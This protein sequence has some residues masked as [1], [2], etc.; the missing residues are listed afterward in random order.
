[1]TTFKPCYVWPNKAF[2]FRLYLNDHNIRIFILENLQHNFEWLLEYSKDFRSTDHFY[3]IIGCHYQDGLANE[4]SRMFDFLDLDR[5]RFT[6]LCND[7][8][9][10][11]LFNKYGFQ[12]RLVNQNAWLDENLVMKPKL[13]D[14]KYDAIYVARLIALK[15]HELCAKVSNLALVAGGSFG[16]EEAKFIPPYLYLND[17]ELTPS[18]VCSKINEAYCGLILSDVEGASFASSEYLLCGIPVVSTHS[19][20]GRDAW[21]DDYNSLVVEA[22]VDAVYEAVM[23]FKES[24]RDPMKIRNDHISRALNYRERF[25]GLLSETLSAVGVDYINAKLF[26]E[27]NFYHKMRVSHTPDLEK[28]FRTIDFN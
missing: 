23:K 20:G 24:P 26:Y 11:F 8:R 17:S 13:L 16:A 3:V 28:I 27:K 22:N 5:K 1:M 18:D 9:E 12:C 21:Y 25:I 15:R 4:A 14:K 6:I 10:E 19:E 2:P 7:L